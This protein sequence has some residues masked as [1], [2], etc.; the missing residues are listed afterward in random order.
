MLMRSIPALA[1]SALLL[2][3]PGLAAAQKIEV[4]RE[5]YLARCTALLYPLDELLLNRLSKENGFPAK[6][7]A[8]LRASRD[9]CGCSFEQ[10]Q[11]ALNPRRLL[12]FAHRGF[13]P[14]E[15]G[16]GQVFEPADREAV[17]KFEKEHKGYRRCAETFERRV[18]EA[19]DSAR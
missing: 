10:A 1:C 7:M 18:Q 11:L 9:V 2:L 6:A 14:V 4:D 3:L 8:Y 15:Q 12:L 19:A 17:A 16:I 5:S 13:E